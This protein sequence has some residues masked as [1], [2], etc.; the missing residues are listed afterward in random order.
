MTEEKSNSITLK[1]ILPSNKLSDNQVLEDQL[2]LDPQ[3]LEKLHSKKTN[4]IV[5]KD[6]SINFGVVG[7]G[8]GG[9]RVCEIFNS[10][11]YKS[12]V[13][14]TA[15]QDLEYINIPEDR[16]I[17]LPFA[18][19]GAGKDLDNG[20]Q[21]VEQNADLIL[22]KIQKIFTEE[23]EMILLAVGGGGGTGSGG[24]EALIG[25]LSILNKPISIIYILPMES[26]DS[27][28]KHN[29]IV[30]LSKLAKMASSDI[31]S[32]LIV[33][34]N[35]KIELLYPGLSKSSFWNVAN[36]A[37][38]KPLHLFNVL[39]ASPTRYDSFDPMDFGRIFTSGDCLIYGV[40]E[41]ENY[42][43]TTAIAEAV[44][45]QMEKSLLASDFNLKES[46]FGGLLVVGSPKAMEN[47]PAENIHYASHMISEVCD[48]AQLTKGVY[49]IEDLDDNSIF[50]YVMFSGLG[51]P[52]ARIEILK[53]EA[54]E[55]MK[56][57][58]NKEKTRASRMEIDYGAGV[59][60][61]GKAQEISSLI[62]K[63]KS[64]FGKLTSN[65]N[66]PDV[67]DRRKR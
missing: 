45:E 63:N 52:S 44:I 14:N 29:S 19:G 17:F 57:I 32:S 5:K 24:A 61:V 55:Q 26:E 60:T 23:N 51:L 2:K 56:Q 46:R 66:R 25:L 58:K 62:K 42:T 20:R 47:L 49:E 27:L 36:N 54:E 3:I 12:C 65:A 40:L 43:E 18:L 67:I 7:L 30:T 4:T 39:S 8:Q 10:F 13:M 11:G 38:V 41:V 21:A 59:G 22:E 37:I 9:G 33:V 16:K 53:T 1:E 64:G 50:V 31:I 34:D 28:S 15:T 35:A 48:Y 6:R